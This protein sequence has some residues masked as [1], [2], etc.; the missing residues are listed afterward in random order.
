MF[1]TSLNKSK[2]ANKQCFLIENTKSTELYIQLIS[3][4]N[5]KQ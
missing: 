2:K 4:L 5:K 3:C 1:L